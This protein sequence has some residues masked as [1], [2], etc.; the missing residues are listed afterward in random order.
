MTIIYP[1]NSS[2][3]FDGS[4]SLNLNKG[5]LIDLQAP[6]HGLTIEVQSGNVWVTQAG[7]TID[8]LLNVRESF[9]VNGPGLVVVQALQDSAFRLLSA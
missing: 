1:R 9:F 8:H 5:A 6:A 7:D 4:I 3:N 2:T